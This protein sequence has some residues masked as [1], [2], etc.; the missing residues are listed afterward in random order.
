MGLASA[1]DATILERAREHAQV[2]VKL[3]ADFHKELA[4]TD[5]E[6]PSVIRIRIEGLQA[7]GLAK[8]LVRVVEA[9]REDL[10]RGELVTVT[11]RGLRLRHLPLVC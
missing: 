10:E 8:L 4:L 2:V 9:C 11:Q 5:A 1:A 6:R 7:K 3:D